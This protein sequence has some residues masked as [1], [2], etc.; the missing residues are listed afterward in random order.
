MSVSKSIQQSEVDFTVM[1]KV[2]NSLN[3]LCIRHINYMWT[4]AFKSRL[5]CIFSVAVCCQIMTHMTHMND[6]KPVG[7]MVG[8][9]CP[10]EQ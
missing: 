8:S 9:E 2:L 1:V 6:N 10:T 4:V 7:L 3:K 5:S